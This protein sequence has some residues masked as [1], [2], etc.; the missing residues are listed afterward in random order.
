MKEL[1][2]I[3][4]NLFSIARDLILR[5]GFLDPI[6]FVKTA[7]SLKPIP[8]QPFLNVN[9]KRDKQILSAIIKGFASAQNA[10]AVYMLSEAWIYDISGWK[11]DEKGYE[12]FREMTQEEKLKIRKEVAIV[13]FRTATG[14]CSMKNA[15][16]NRNNGS[17]W[18]DQDSEWF[19]NCGSGFIPKWTG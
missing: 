14:D 7:D 6:I 3:G 10:T 12:K 18:L 16:I 19:T 17:A 11:S 9:S 1:Q 13:T 15:R 4:D 8:V 5:D 2:E